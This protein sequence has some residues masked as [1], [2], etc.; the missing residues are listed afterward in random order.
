LAQPCDSDEFQ[1]HGPAHYARRQYKDAA[2]DLEQAAKLDSNN[3]DGYDVLEIV[4][5]ARQRNENA[6]SAFMQVLE[7]IRNQP[8]GNRTR[9]DI[10][11]RLAPEHINSI[12]K[13]NCNLEREIWQR[14]T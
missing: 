6:V 11:H 13:D 8:E 14:T 4:H 7:L 12:T 1:Q 2:K 10:L 5:K 9:N 3:I